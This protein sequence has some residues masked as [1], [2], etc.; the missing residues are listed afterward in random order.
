[1]PRQRFKHT[2]LLYLACAIVD[3]ANVQVILSLNHLRGVQCCGRQ[4]SEARRGAPSGRLLAA[5][6]MR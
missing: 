4:R 3:L 6:G 5:A 2:Y 1:M